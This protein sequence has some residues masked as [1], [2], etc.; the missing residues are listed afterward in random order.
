MLQLRKIKFKLH[1]LKKYY[2]IVMLNS[3]I[4]DFDV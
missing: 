3:T 2:T 1:P 4:R